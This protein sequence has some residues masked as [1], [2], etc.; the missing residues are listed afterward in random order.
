MFKFILKVLNVEKLILIFD[1]NV[2]ENVREKMYKGI[3]NNVY[4]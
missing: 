2:K 4:K 3:E 1:I